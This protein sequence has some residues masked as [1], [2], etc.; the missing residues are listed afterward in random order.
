M[1]I[2][3]QPGHWTAESRCLDERVENIQGVRESLPCGTKIYKGGQSDS[4]I[5]RSLV[6]SVLTS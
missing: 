5:F 3:Y 6:N 4:G 2:L 1:K